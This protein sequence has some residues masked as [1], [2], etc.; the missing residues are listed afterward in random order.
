MWFEFGHVT[1]GSG[2][3]K[4]PHSTVGVVHSS[5]A[6]DGVTPALDATQV[7]MNGCFGQL[8]Y[9]CHLEEVAPA[10]D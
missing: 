2:M 10:G 9:K 4:P 8:P 7:Q 6:T 3:A 5:P 1:A